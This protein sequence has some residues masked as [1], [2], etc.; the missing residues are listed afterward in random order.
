M[1]D[2]DRSRD[3]LQA[4]ILLPF[5][6]AAGFQSESNVFLLVADMNT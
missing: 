4:P 2:P 1:S 5:Q 3:P 6:A